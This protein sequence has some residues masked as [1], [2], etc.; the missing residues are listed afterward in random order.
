MFWP[1]GSVPCRGS[2]RRRGE[3]Q[4]VCG[5]HLFGNVQTVEAS[6]IDTAACLPDSLEPELQPS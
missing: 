6:S 5:Q 2:T 4:I 1:R 3:A